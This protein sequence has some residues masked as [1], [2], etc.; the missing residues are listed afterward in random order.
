MFRNRSNNERLVIAFVLLIVVSTIINTAPQL[1]V[2]LAIMAFIYF[3]QQ[4]NEENNN[5][6]TTDDTWDRERQ[7]PRPRPIRRERPSNVEQIHQHALR[8]VRAAG[9]DPNTIKVLPVD[10]G[11]IA[12]Q[13][14]DAPSIHR[15]TSVP[16]DSDYIQPFAELR[17]PVDATGKV[18]FEIYDG[19]RRQIFVHED[20]HELKR[21]RNLV[22]PTARLPIHDEL[23]TDGNWE[24]RIS[25]DNVV[26]SRH[27]FQWVDADIAPGSEDDGGG[28]RDHIREDGEISN[29]LRAMMAE[30]RLGEMSLDELLAFQDEDDQQ[31][32][33]GN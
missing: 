11:M 14:E 10:M 8:A 5:D 23:A 30:S 9:H 13:G 2:L 24:L 18:R 15:N 4:R 6:Y 3:Y 21:G 29:E 27:I 25:A 19:S 20:Y 28:L 22:S 7:E 31:Q 1:F 32:Q 26:L 17:V 12:F 33:S 16:D